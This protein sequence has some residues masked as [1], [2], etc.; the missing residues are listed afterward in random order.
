MY[1]EN[2]VRYKSK[3]CMD[4]RHAERYQSRYSF[5]ARR[6]A[7]SALRDV[8]VAFAKREG[9]VVIPWQAVVVDTDVANKLKFQSPQTPI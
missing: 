1:F 5:I 8:R 4:G 7:S 2:V 3:K 9:I 6:R